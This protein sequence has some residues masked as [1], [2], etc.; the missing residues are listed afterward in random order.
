[1]YIDMIPFMERDWPES[2]PQEYTRVVL[3]NDSSTKSDCTMSESQEYDHAYGKI[4]SI[5]ACKKEVD[6][7]TILDPVPSPDSNKLQAPKVLMDGAPGIG[8]TTLTLNACKEWAENRLFKQYDLVLLVPLR[9]ASLREAKDIEEFL[10]GDDQDLKT[11]VVQYIQKNNGENI[12]FIFDGYDELSYDQRHRSD[13]LFMKIFR[14]KKLTKC[15]IWITSRPYTSNELKKAPSI[16]NR[17]IEVLGFNK[18]QIYSCIRKQ[19]KD[20]SIATNLISQL[21]EREDIASLCYIPLVC[22]IM[23]HV[24]ESRSAKS[25]DS[26]VSLPATM[27]KL[28]ETFLLDMLAREVLV[29]ENN[30]ELEEEDFHDIY[31]FPDAVSGR[32]DVLDSLAYMIA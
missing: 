28:I 4:D 1:M 9:Q 17:H 21:E 29:V 15:A 16:I 20:I 25:P 12:A 11:K 2:N 7:S 14:G 3:V 13:S 32:L 8:K 5:L 31:N 27:T 26:Q 24:Y 18:E 19:I 30:T 6:V 22:I 10:P 23:I